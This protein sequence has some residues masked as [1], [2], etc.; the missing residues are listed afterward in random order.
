MNP[1]KKGVLAHG[2]QWCLFLAWGLPGLS[3]SGG[4]AEKNLKLIRLP[5]GFSISL[6]AAA[7]P[8][9]RSLARGSKGTVFVGSRGE[10]KV[11]ALVDR[12]HDHRADD[13]IVIASGL[14]MPNGV[15]FR[16][17]SLFV[18]EIS[19]ILRFDGIEGRLGNPPAPVVVSR[20]FPPDRHHGWK[21]IRFG[22]DGKLYVPVGAPCN[23]CAPADPYA[24]LTR[25]DADGSHFEI[26]ARG[27]RNTVGFDWHPLSGELWFTENGRD[28]LGNDSPPDELNRAPGAGLHF[29]FPYCHGLSLPDPGF[30][31]KR[32]CADFSPPMLE[33]P[34]H[35][36]ALGMRFYAGS[37][38]PEKYRE[39]VFIAEHGSWNRWPPAGY[40]ITM[41]KIVAGRA[42][43]YET[44]AAGWL[45]GTRAWGR[46]V[47]L[48]ILPDGSMLVSDDKAGAVYRIAY[49][50]TG[51]RGR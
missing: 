4:E 3:G 34:A 16:D 48:E 20:A 41:A 43:A 25:I 47:D 11:Y 22:P 2:L 45:Q 21:F 5:P 28:W 7:V 46:P 24:S 36:A 26:F 23:V 37:M 40:R 9:A 49:A 31:R 51:P 35:S 44:F 19:R 6:F 30:G 15:A 12:D 42:S 33:L 8:G 18:A 38:F 50:A 27:I 32:K 14:D 13:V 17:G 1:R 39:R 29:G 10:G